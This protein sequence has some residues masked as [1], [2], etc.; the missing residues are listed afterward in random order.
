MRFISRLF[1]MMSLALCLFSCHQPAQKLLV[2]PGDG[3]GQLQHSIDSAKQ[4][5]DL[6]MYG[7]TDENLANA[8]IRAHRRDVKVRVMLQHHPYKNEHENDVMVS[9]L[10]HA[11]V[12]VK[13]SNPHF[14]ITHQKTLIVDH[15]AAYVMTFNFTYNTLHSERNFALLVKQPKQIEEIE[16]VFNADW[17]GEKDFKQHSKWLVWSPGNSE[18]KIIGLIASAKH[19]VKVYN[20]EFAS[21]PVMRALEQKA[22]SGVEVQ[23][24]V[25]WKNYKMYK[26]NLHAVAAKGVEVKLQRNLYTHAKVVLIDAGYT[27]ARTLVGSMNFSYYGLDKNRELG[28]IDADERVSQQ[29]LAVFQ[30]DWKSAEPLSIGHAAHAQTVTC[31]QH[32]CKLVA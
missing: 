32:M 26:H 24:I 20:Q 11:G 8:L 30:S 4:S 23:L 19:S 29:M 25:P 17:K 14:T 16:K 27:E 5:V 1:I 15:K 21:T 13:W 7:F 18:K 9:K 6:V 31:E 22:E 2:L 10:K 28:V 12:T 3:F